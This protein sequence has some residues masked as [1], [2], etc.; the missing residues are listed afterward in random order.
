[1]LP[2]SVVVAA[3]PSALTGSASH[4]DSRANAIDTNA[5]TLTSTFEGAPWKGE[6]R[7]AATDRAH[8]EQREQQRIA[9]DFTGLAATLRSASASMTHLVDTL[10]SNADAL[11][12]EMFDVAED[13]KVTDTYNYPLAFAIADAAGNADARAQLKTMQRRR[14]HEAADATKRLTHLA[15]E[16]T[17][18]DRKTAAAI[19]AHNRQIGNLAPASAGLSSSR[20]KRDM[21]IL[22]GKNNRDGSHPT[23]GQIQNALNDLHLAA[24]LDATQRQQLSHDGRTQMSQAQFDYLSE[25]L[26]R[27]PSNVSDLDGFGA[28]SLTPAQRDQLHGDL[29]DAMRIV[30]NPSISTS[31][32]KAGGMKQ[33]PKQIQKLLTESPTQLDSGMASD[34]STAVKQAV[35][36]RHL[37]DF[38][39]LTNTLAH[40]DQSLRMG[41]DVDRGLLKQASEIAGQIGPDD[42]WS[43]YYGHYENGRMINDDHAVGR[44]LN[45]MLDNAAGD[46]RAVHDF[47]TGQN[48]SPTVTSGNTYVASSHMTDLLTHTWSPDQHGVQHVFDWMSDK[49]IVGDHGL[50]GRLA[51]ESA[52]TLGHYLSTNAD[53]L[54]HIRTPSGDSLGTDSYTTLGRINPDLTQHLASSLSP[55]LGNFADAPE[56]L[57]ANHS[58]HSFGTV[59]EMSNMFS[60]IDG[61]PNAARTINHA[62]N[63]WMHAIETDAGRHPGDSG[64]WGHSAGL[65]KS[66]VDGGLVDQQQAL[67]D[68]GEWNDT[69]SEEARGTAIDT[70]SAAAGMVPYAG[71]A[72]GLLSPEVKLNLLGEPTA[73]GSPGSDWDQALDAIHDSP[74]GDSLV[75]QYEWAKGYLQT[76]PN[77]PEFDEYMVDGKLDW[78]RIQDSKRTF[79]GFINQTPGFRNFD[80]SYDQGLNDKAIDP[81]SIPNPDGGH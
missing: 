45:A 68:N 26:K 79:N 14:G 51:G 11:T 56:S 44:T 7:D 13:W 65:L 28:S 27:M 29:G 58:V 50:Q 67:K 33:L 5:R 46:H 60:V 2:R 40:G 55:Y 15:T 49:S 75:R 19:S 47:I 35:K 64:G 74:A 69:V 61:D 62:A 53:S 10:R 8:R 18:I 23:Q 63:D 72:A 76:H 70:A 39:A 31:G 6:A 81:E 16:L 22:S 57:L 43:R 12:G 36:V 34:T 73:P 30:G 80:N 66:A 1:M 59:G 21:D 42:Q 17:D 24:D 71:S 3:N 77:A 54:N 41:S 9:D 38:T 52:D 37:G 20:A 48:M 25:T 32:G 78:D 4:L